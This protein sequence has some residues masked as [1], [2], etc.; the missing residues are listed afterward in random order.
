M[1]KIYLYFEILYLEFAS[2]FG[3]RA[4]NFLCEA[5]ALSAC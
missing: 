4:S 1:L 2:C 3:F 5:Q